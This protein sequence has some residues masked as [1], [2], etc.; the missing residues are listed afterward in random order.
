MGGLVCFRHGSS[1]PQ[2][3]LGG[4]CYALGIVLAVGL[5][6]ASSVPP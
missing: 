1:L 2:F 3:L 4:L 6:L 5:P